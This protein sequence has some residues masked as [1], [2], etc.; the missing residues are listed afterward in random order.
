[1]E[2]GDA[3]DAGGG[4]DASNAGDAGDALAVR[5]GARRTASGRGPWHVW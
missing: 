2:T 4:G 1:M 5:S 3:G